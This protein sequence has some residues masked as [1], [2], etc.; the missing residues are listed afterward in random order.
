MALSGGLLQRDVGNP[1]PSRWEQRK[2]HLPSLPSCPPALSLGT[3]PSLSQARGKRDPLPRLT[4]TSPQAQSRQSGESS[5]GDQQQH[6]VCPF[7]GTSFS[8]PESKILPNPS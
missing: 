3:G 7:Q 2:K 6:T 1:Q 5:S 8:D 4:Q